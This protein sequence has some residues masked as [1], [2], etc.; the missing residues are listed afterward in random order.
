MEIFKLANPKSRPKIIVRNYLLMLNRIKGNNIHYWYCQKKDEHCGARAITKLVGKDHIVLKCSE[1]NHPASP[2]ELRARQ[3]VDRV[4]ECAT[5][6]EYSAKHIIQNAMVSVSNTELPHLPSSCALTAVINRI[7]QRQK[8]KDP[9]TS[10]DIN[11][12]PTLRITCNNQPFLIIDVTLGDDRILVFSTVDDVIRLAQGHWIIDGVSRIF[13]PI[14]YRLCTILTKVGLS[15]GRI[16]PM[17]YIL[18]TSKSQEAYVKAFEEIRNFATGNG[19][20]LAPQLIISNLEREAIDATET[21]FPGVE[22]KVCFYHF[23]QC[24][25]HKIKSSGLEVQYNSDLDF[26][27]TMKQ[28]TALAFVPWENIPQAFDEVAK[29]MPEGTQAI[30]EWMKECYVNGKEQILP[31]GTVTRTPPM[32]PPKMWSVYN[33]TTH[34]IPCTQNIVKVWHQRW[35]KLISRSYKMRF[36]NVIENFKKEQHE[37]EGV[38]ELISKGVPRPNRNI[39]LIKKGKKIAA[40]VGEYHTLELLDYLQRLSPYLS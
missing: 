32:F 30:V 15:N 29:V 19:A 10:A 31:D 9:Q 38:V 5:N 24:M 2:H 11:I 37:V 26:A 14:S 1:H 35:E 34:G 7:R 6:T 21:V 23:E 33:S 25:W 39:K 13:E 16:L 12:S 18:M 17:V 8:P 40:I 3:F 22:N 36:F 28:L 4:K 20:T 27:H